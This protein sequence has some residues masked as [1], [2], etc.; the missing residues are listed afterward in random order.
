MIE[1]GDMTPEQ[2]KKMSDAE[3]IAQ[4]KKFCKRYCVGNGKD[5]KLKNYSKRLFF[6]ILNLRFF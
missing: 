5:F 3:L 4:A 1:N 6:C 2:L